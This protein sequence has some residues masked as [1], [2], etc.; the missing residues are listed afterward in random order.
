MP[1]IN[2]MT[3]VVCA[4]LGISRATVARRRSRLAAPPAIVHARP[5]PPRALT[6]P[7]RQAVLNL[8]HAPGVYPTARPAAVVLSNSRPR[9]VTW[10]IYEGSRNPTASL[11]LLDNRLTEGPAAGTAWQDENQSARETNSQGGDGIRYV[12]L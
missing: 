12:A 7:Q 5:R 4:A 1:P 6:T 3:S 11:I 9:V 2:G 10:C 8:L